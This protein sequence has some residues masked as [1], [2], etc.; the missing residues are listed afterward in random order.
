MPLSA[1]MSE[2]KLSR[3]DFFKLTRTVLLTASGLLGLGGLMRFLSYQSQPPAQSDFDLG[4][5]VD[6]AAG[7]S[8]VLPIVPAVLIRSD[9]GFS[10]LSLICTHLGCTV[11]SQ[12]EGFACPC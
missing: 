2:P 9:K 5:A 8:T 12:M 1:K 3:R 11:E 4:S 6:Y 7:S 10:A